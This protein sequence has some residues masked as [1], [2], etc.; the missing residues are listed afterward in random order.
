[1]SLYGMKWIVESEGG[2]F[3]NTNYR[4]ESTFSSAL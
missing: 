4:V 2:V 1:M 3:S